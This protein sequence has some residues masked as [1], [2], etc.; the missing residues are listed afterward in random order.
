MASSSRP[1][2]ARAL[3]S[4]HGI[5]VLTLNC[6]G[7]KYISTL[8]RERLKEIGRKLAEATPALDIVGLQELWTQEDYASI[9]SQTRHILP[10]GKFYYSGIFGGGLAIL[11]KWPIVESSMMRYPLNGRPNAFYH[12]D[13]YVGKGVACAKIRYGPGN[14]DIAEVF[15]T[16]VCRF[17]AHSLLLMESNLQSFMPHTNRPNMTHIYVTEL[18]KHGK[19]QSSCAALQIEAISSWLLATLI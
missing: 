15:T 1:S 8:R 4:P 3:N 16:H 17:I 5:N 18:H 2:T 9:R 13:W 19:Y 11:S 12:G 6:W 10:Y 7:L 14:K